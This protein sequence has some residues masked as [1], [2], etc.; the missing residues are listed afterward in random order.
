MPIPIGASVNGW[1]GHK[2]LRSDNAMTYRLK[3]K[4]KPGQG[5]RRIL[6]EQTEWSLA[7][8]ADGANAVTGVHETRKAMKRVRALLLL[9]R[10][11]FAPEE[12]R[13]LDDQYRRI[14][15]LLGGQRDRDVLLA[16]LDLIEQEHDCV[17]RAQLALVR[18]AAESQAWP[19]GQSGD[20]EA[21]LAEARRLLQKSER[22]IDDIR[23]SPDTTGMMADGLRY[24]LQRCG[25]AYRRAVSSAEPAVW[26][27]W[28]KTVQ[29]HWRHMKLVDRAWPEYFG[30]REALGSE[31]ADVLGQAQD[32]DVLR[33]FLASTACTAIA[34]DARLA[35][36]ALA[37]DSIARRRAGA[38]PLGERL[39]AERPRRFA[40][41]ARLYWRTAK[42]L[43]R[44]STR[45]T[46]AMAGRKKGG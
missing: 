20:R 42:T 38:I 29:Q 11:G 40:N 9:M 36:D 8:L 2:A 17:Q 34:G 45:Q 28:R 33:Q 27:D 21:L 19:K 23:L 41:R 16:T 5:L 35:L 43:R 18:L 15:R 22:Q 37:E 39:L 24:T 14:G 10:G 44:L 30:A 46:A 7:S 1:H 3:L 12:R 25:K 13:L 6:R 4:E 31:L 32:L 26:H